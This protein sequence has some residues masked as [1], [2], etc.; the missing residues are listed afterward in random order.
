MKHLFIATA[1]VAW[2]PLA[3][4]ADS[5]AGT[6]SLSGNPVVETEQRIAISNANT[7]EEK[8]ALADEE[9]EGTSPI[10]YRNRNGHS[11]TNPTVAGLFATDGSKPFDDDRQSL[12]DEKDED[13]WWIF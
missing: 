6:N 12:E 3:A 7:A 1:L 9:M 11:S 2:L 8:Q 10:S 5:V 13:G 4:H